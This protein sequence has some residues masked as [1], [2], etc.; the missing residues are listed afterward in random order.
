MCRVRLGH[1]QA[2][3]SHVG[4]SRVNRSPQSRSNPTPARHRRSGHTASGR[5]DVPGRVPE[6]GRTGTHG[7]AERGD[8]ITRRLARS[9]GEC[10][11]E[12]QTSGVPQGA[13]QAHDTPG[14]VRK[15][16]RSNHG[17]TIKSPATDPG[18]W[19]LTCGNWWAI[20]GLN[21][22]PLPCQGTSNMELSSDFSW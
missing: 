13:A 3:I 17:Q 20:L 21:Q 15:F 1:Q 2:L 16:S 22:W 10:R 5:P 9:P 18:N 14:D 4:T 6:S 19:A 11:K 7:K 8:A 12:Q